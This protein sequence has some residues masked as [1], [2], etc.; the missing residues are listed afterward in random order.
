MHVLPIVL[1]VGTTVAFSQ[2]ITTGILDGTVGDA[3]DTVVVVAEIVVTN[4]DN[5]QT[6]RTASDERGHWV[7]PSMPPAM[8]RVSVT[9]AEFR[10]TTIEG[11]KIDAGVPSTVNVRLEVGQVTERI[12]VESGATARSRMAA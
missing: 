2:V 3:Q 1:Y 9:M 7:F 4:A 8:Y 11:V 12:D 6:F 10:T 5:G